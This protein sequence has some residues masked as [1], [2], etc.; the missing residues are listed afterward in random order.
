MV[1]NKASKHNWLIDAILFSGY[2]LDV[3]HGIDRHCDA[4]VGSGC[5]SAVLQFIISSIIGIG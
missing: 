2:D 1:K 4:P 5:A 3:L